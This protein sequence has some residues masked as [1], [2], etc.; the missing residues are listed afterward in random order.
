MAEPFLG[1]IKIF[2]GN[3]APRG[4]ALCQGQLLAISQN[5]ALFSL[6]GTTYGGDGITTFALPDLRGRI[7]IG[8]G[9]GPGLSDRTIGE[10]GGTPTVTVAAAAMPFHTHGVACSTAAGTATAPGGNFWAANANTGLPQ[11]ATTSNSS[12]NP[13]AVSIAGGNQP[14]ANMMPFLAIHFII[15]LEG[16]YPSRN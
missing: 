6:L 1:E 10:Q 2:A 11:F 3:F 4:Y 16:I 13:A 9:Q 14:H 8:Q 12:M 7:P 15:A 5:S